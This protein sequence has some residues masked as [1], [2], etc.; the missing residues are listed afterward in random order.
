MVTVSI[1][2]NVITGAG[3][4]S[5]TCGFTFGA[6]IGS[7]LGSVIFKFTACFVTS[8]GEIRASIST[9]LVG[10]FKSSKFTNPQLLFPLV[11]D[12]IELSFSIVTPPLEE[13]SISFHEF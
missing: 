3:N 6:S 5:F 13:L 1:T 2:G 7:T 11:D 4:G 8:F 12:P 10:S 9:S